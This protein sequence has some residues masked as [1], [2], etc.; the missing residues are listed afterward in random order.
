M[1]FYVLVFHASISIDHFQKGLYGSKHKTKNVKPNN[2]E[3]TSSPQVKAYGSTLT[4]R[5]FHFFNA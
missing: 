5:L 1:W 2:L 3:V 4:P